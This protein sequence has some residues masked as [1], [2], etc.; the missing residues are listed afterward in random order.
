[1]DL[2]KNDK[3]IAPTF[4][5]GI[6][7]ILLISIYNN[8]FKNNKFT[9]N[10]YILNSYLYILL[11]LVIVILE[12]LILDYNNITV[13]KLFGNIN[14]IVSYLLFF[15]L[16]LGLLT[17][18]MFINP[19]NII[20][21]HIFWLLFAVSIGT[22][23]YPSYIISKNKNVLLE[24]LFTLISILIIF[25]SIAFIRPDLI[26]LSLGPILVFVLIGIIIYQFIRFF[27]DKQNYRTP[28]WLSYIVIVVFIL[29][30]LY[31]TKLIQIH[32][33]NCI[34][35]K[36]DYINESLGIFLDVIN[37]FQHLVNVH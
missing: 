31:D 29:F 37:L 36:A 3:L 9:C 26:S 19:K 6:L 27:N 17:I 2:K 25:S 15:I 8:A 18:T 12:I 14:N 1:M 4:L 10:K 7:G 22:I 13:N 28:K 21:K 34:E 30:I 23:L 33:K 11:I 24:V 5:I 35:G 16:I 20:L 32:A